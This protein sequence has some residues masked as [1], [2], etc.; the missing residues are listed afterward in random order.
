MKAAINILALYLDCQEDNDPVITSVE[1]DIIEK[2]ENDVIDKL[3]IQASVYYRNLNNGPWFTINKDLHFSGASLNK[4]PLAIA[5]LK[6]SE[7][8]P[9]ILDKEITLDSNECPHRPQL[10]EPQDELV[11]GQNYTVRYLLE[12]LLTQSNNDAE[13][14]LFKNI[15]YKFIRKVYN[16]LGLEEVQL[17]RR[18][19]EI[20]IYETIAPG[21][22]LDINNTYYMQVKYYSSI[23]RMLY[24]SS[25]LNRENSEYILNILSSSTF[26]EGITKQLPDDITVSHKFGSKGDVYGNDS[27]LDKYSQ[28][29]DCGIVYYPNNPYLLCV[30]TKGQVSGVLSEAISNISNIIFEAISFEK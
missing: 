25:F 10:F 21:V 12:K 9:G 1:K 13:C 22:K 16:D 20:S 28:L 14:M 29:H 19:N 15:D 27:I 2:I 24:N 3:D 23:F 5:Y 6:L 17:E 30:M 11:N 4:I 7:A 26:N 8:T 18:N